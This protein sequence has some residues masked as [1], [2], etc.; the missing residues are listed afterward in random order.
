L[1]PLRIVRGL[2]FPRQFIEW[3]LITS[4]PV[5]ILWHVE[6]LAFVIFD[7]GTVLIAPAITFSIEP[8]RYRL[9]VGVGRICSK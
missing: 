5:A 6:F 2:I 9:G 3:W 7:V 8:T 1:G 4:C